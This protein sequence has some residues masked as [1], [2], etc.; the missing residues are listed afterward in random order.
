M[1]L[2]MIIVALVGAISASLVLWGKPPNFVP[3]RA[4]PKL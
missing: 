2:S 1:L 3:M 4:P